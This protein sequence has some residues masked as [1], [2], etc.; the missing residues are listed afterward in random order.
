MTYLHFERSYRPVE[1]EE[2]EGEGEQEEEQEEEEGQEAEEEEDQEDR[3]RRKKSRM[4]MRMIRRR[5][6]RS[7]KRRRRRMR[8]R[9]RRRR[10][11]RRRRKR[12][13]TRQWS[14]HQSQH[15]PCHNDDA[16]DGG[17]HAE[18]DH[19]RLVDEQVSLQEV[20]GLVGAVAALAERGA[21]PQGLKRQLLQ[22][23]SGRIRPYVHP[24]GATD[25]RPLF[26]ST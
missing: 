9:R 26:G 4:R 20:A 22:I 5:K 14:G 24:W 15:P 25:I 12:R 8:R 7:K 16:A 11:Q 21:P 18:G 17:E 1:E 3:R 13:S 2:E 23:L 19:D 10:R 6:G